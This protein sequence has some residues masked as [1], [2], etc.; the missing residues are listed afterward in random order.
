M[1]AISSAS[2]SCISPTERSAL[3]VSQPDW[4]R[5]RGLQAEAHVTVVVWFLLRP[6]EQQ[7]CRSQLQVCPFLRGHGRHGTQ[8]KSQH[9]RR[10][11]YAPNCHRPRPA[12][13]RQRGRHDDWFPVAKQAE[14]SA[15]APAGLAFVEAR[16]E[17]T[18]VTNAVGTSDPPPRRGTLSLRTSGRGLGA[19]T[20]ERSCVVFV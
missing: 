11:R 15:T 4:F 19:R 20:S 2:R 12:G 8:L 6:R 7:R 18:W 14:P 9:P 13:D 17:V 10:N 5:L 16:P 1:A 3:S